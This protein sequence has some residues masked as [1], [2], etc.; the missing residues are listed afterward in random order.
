MKRS[1]GCISGSMEPCLRFQTSALSCCLEPHVPA[2]PDLRSAGVGACYLHLLPFLLSLSPLP[3]HL[4]S[5]TPRMYV[6]FYIRPLEANFPLQNLKKIII[7][8]SLEAISTLHVCRPS[9]F[10]YLLRSSTVPSGSWP[11]DCSP[12][13]KVSASP[14]LASVLW[15]SHFSSQ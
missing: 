1:L 15:G 3:P 14:G 4:S 8:I 7:E 5:P 9:L 12:Y 11:G 13:R 2:F 10:L 6:S